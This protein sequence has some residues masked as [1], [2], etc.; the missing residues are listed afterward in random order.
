M[1]DFF[2]LFLEKKQILD[3]NIFYLNLLV[4]NKLLISFEHFQNFFKVKKL[5]SSHF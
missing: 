4:V 5:L 2:H 3:T 1:L